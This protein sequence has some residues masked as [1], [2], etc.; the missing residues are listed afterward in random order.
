MTAPFSDLPKS[1][2]WGAWNQYSIKH[3]FHCTG[4]VISLRTVHTSSVERFS[5]YFDQ[6]AVTYLIFFVGTHCF[7]KCN[8]WKNSLS[9]FR[10]RRGHQ[11]QTTLKPKTMK[12]LIEN[13]SKIDEIQNLA[14][15]SWQPW[16]HQKGFREFF[17]KLHFWNQCVP[18]KKM[19]YVTAFWS[20]FSLNLFTEEVWWVW[21]L[22][23]YS[24]APCLSLQKSS[25]N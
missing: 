13:S 6:K 9:P 12:I 24:H 15:L 11:V 18:T 17:Q 2:G 20:K 25:S 3:R 21:H 22:N 16:R 1:G 19:R 8:F 23:Q 4:W 7:Q 14:S 10:G 5:E